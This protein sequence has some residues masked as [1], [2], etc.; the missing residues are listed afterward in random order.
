MMR[1]ESLE[2]GGDLVRGDEVRV[3]GAEGLSLLGLAAQHQEG[4][5]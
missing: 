1:G 4:R 3:E 2:G 5:G